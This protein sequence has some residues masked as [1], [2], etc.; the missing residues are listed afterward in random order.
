MNGT[1]TKILISRYPE[2][3]VSG[4]VRVSLSRQEQGHQLQELR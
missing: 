4:G 3:G 1:E 2:T